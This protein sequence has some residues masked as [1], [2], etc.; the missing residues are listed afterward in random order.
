M[1]PAAGVSGTA[2]ITVTVTDGKGESSSQS[3]VMTVNPGTAAGAPQIIV[4]PASQTLGLGSSVALDVT[5]TGTP[6]LKYQWR[7]N[8]ANIPGATGPTYPIPA[9]GVA[10]DGD[11][12][13][14]VANALG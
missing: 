7:L 4:P 1:T 9:F 8:G 2:T 6:P 3:F 12:R 11:Y 10:N 5:A 14:T 13:V